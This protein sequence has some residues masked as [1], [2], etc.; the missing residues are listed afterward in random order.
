[1]SLLM[2]NRG[3]I[4]SLGAPTNNNFQIT[5]DTSLGNGA[6]NFIVPLPSGQTYDFIVYHGDGNSTSYS[7]SSPSITI[8]YTSGG[9]YQ[10]SFVGKVGGWGFNNTGDRAKVLSIDNWGDIGID[11]CDYAF[12]GCSNL[13]SIPNN[14]I[15]WTNP[16]DFSGFFR[17]TPNLT[18]NIPSKLF[19]LLVNASNFQQFF[20]QSGITGSLPIDLLRNNVLL[21]NLANF[22]RES[23]VSGNIPSDFLRYNTLLTNLTYAFVS[24]GLGG[25]TLPNRLFYYNNLVTNYSSTFRLVNNLTLGDEMFNLAEI[26]RVS[27]FVDFMRV[28]VTAFSHTGTIQDIWNYAISALSTNAFVNQT[29]ISNYTYIP[30]LWKGL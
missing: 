12:F 23:G 13:S 17:A 21:T 10:V 11:K 2:A 15:T 18:V 1:M 29:G 22:L 7:G 6:N 24:G 8:N 14:S 30:D 26:Y 3:L 28:T 4:R 19:K 27:S 9:V 20:Y 16:S 25:G 5:I